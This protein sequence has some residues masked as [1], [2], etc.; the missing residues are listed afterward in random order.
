MIPF[1]TLP[2]PSSL[3][4]DDFVYYFTQKV[5]DISSSLPLL[6]SSC[7]YPHLCCTHFIPLSS[8]GVNRIVTTNNATTCPLYPTPSRLQAVSSDILPFLTTTPSLQALFQRPSRQTG[9]IKSL[10]KKLTLDTIDIQNYRPVSLLSFL[11]K[12]M[13]RAI[14]NQL[15][16]TKIT[17]IDQ[18]L[19]CQQF[20]VTCQI[21]LISHP[22]TDGNDSFVGLALNQP[23]KMHGGMWDWIVPNVLQL[24]HLLLHSIS[25]PGTSLFYP[26]SGL[27]FYKTAEAYVHF[28]QH[29]VG[30][31]MD[32][33][34]TGTNTRAHSTPWYTRLSVLLIGI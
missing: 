5:R 23:S 19:S 27:M 11:S 22:Y 12:T 30:M 1:S 29:H 17:L 32:W 10:L 3:T 2:P 25:R 21:S 33:Y 20:D 24:F 18:S 4:V 15:S 8:E 9:R 7:P 16:P 6:P 28:S 13:E 34:K 26:V 14:S 31:H